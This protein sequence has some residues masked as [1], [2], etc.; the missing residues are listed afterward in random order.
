MSAST[1]Q[2]QDICLVVTENELA[3]SPIGN[4]LVYKL[5][6]ELL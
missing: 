2:L 1:S 4:A 6:E 3:A 5:S